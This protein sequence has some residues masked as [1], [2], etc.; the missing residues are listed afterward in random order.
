[1]AFTLFWRAQVE[2]AHDY[3]LFVHVL[4]PQGAVVAGWDAMPMG[5]GYPTS[6]W[7]SGERVPDER[8][9]PLPE[10]LPPGEYSI[11]IG[12][13]LPATGERLPAVDGEGEPVPNGALEVGSFLVQ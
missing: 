2:P 8:S 6:V 9:V 12:W 3:T 11:L 1:L 4:N 13:Y 10:D 7:A 5:G